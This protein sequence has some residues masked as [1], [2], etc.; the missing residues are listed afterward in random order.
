MLSTWMM[1]LHRSIGAAIQSDTSGE[2]SGSSSGANAGGL[3]G[4]TFYSNMS[5]ASG[6][7]GFKKM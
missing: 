7:G 2:S 3:R 5:V 6:G 4:S 1:A